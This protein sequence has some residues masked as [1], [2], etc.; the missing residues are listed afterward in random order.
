MKER[1]KGVFGNKMTPL[2]NYKD[3]YITS[4]NNFCILSIINM[5]YKL[6]EVKDCLMK[7]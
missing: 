2:E 5:K 3:L 1:F 6:K 7:N 4:L